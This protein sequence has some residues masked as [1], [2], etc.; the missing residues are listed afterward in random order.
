MVDKAITP[1]V[2]RVLC[3]RKA[4]RLATSPEHFVMLLE[5]DSL[6]GIKKLYSLD[7]AHFYAKN[8]DGNPAFEVLALM[9]CLQ[10]SPLAKCEHVQLA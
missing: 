1:L 2:I 10:T 7:S 4:R 3:S 9:I 6:A 8:V 5:V